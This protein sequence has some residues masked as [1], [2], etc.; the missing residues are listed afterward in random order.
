MSARLESIRL[1]LIKV[2]FV[3]LPLV[4]ALGQAPEAQADLV[5]NALSSRSKGGDDATNVFYSNFVGMP[6]D[7]TVDSVSI[8]NQGKAGSFDFYHLRP[9]SGGTAF[10]ILD[11]VGAFTPNTGLSGTVESFSLPSAVSVQ[12]GDWFAHYGNGISWS[13]AGETNADNPHPLYLWGSAAISSAI[14]NG[15]TINIDGSTPGYGRTSYNRD[16]A[17]AVNLVE[18]TAPVTTDITPTYLAGDNYNRI[19]SGNGSSATNIDGNRWNYDLGS[20]QQ[21]MWFDLGDAFKAGFTDSQ[22]LSATLTWSGSVQSSLV[23]NPTVEGQIGIFAAPDAVKGTDA[24][25]ADVPSTGVIPDYYNSHLA[26]VIDSVTATPGT[27]LSAEWDITEL[28]QA[29]LDDPSDPLF[30]E[31]LLLHSATP[32]A[33]NWAAPGPTF[34]ITTIAP[35]PSS[36]GLLLLGGMVLL[37]RRRRR[38]S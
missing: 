4:A 32:L 38:E 28:V 27:V 7:G 25:L 29:W 24:V 26:D 3:I 20:N 10:Q 16:Y 36:M 5:G 31:F 2:S 14:T 1:R 8:W 30:G 34:V 35:E 17:W 19:V 33:V 21:Y 23:G 6:I 18:Y 37:G 9:Q 15:T 12:A 13:K 22:L 11:N